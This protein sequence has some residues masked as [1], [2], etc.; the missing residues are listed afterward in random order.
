MRPNSI[1]LPN[2][3]NPLLRTFS[4]YARAPWARTAW[5]EDGLHF[6]LSG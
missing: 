1:Q 5:S 4:G 6:K 3:N 2:P